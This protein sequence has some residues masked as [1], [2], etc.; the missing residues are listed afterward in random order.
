MRRFYSAVLIFLLVGYFVGLAEAQFGRK[1]AEGAGH[2]FYQLANFPGQELSQSKLFVFLSI[3]HDALVFVRT[4]SGFAAHYKLG[5]YLYGE[6]KNLLFE[7]S[8]RRTVFVKQYDDTN[9]PA[10]F[11][12]LNVSTTQT[13]G[14]YRL[15]L[16]LEDREVPKP[17]ILEKEVRIRDFRK[18]PLQLSSLLLLG[19]APDSCG[20]GV[21]PEPEAVANF[22][23]DFLVCFE[24]AK[25]VPEAAQL[26]LEVVS[27]H[28]RTVYQADT[29][30]FSANSVRKCFV[31]P[32]D[33]TPLRNGYYRIRVKAFGLKR[34]PPVETDFRVTKA[35]EFQNEQ[36]LDDAI[37]VLSY[38]ARPEE[39]EKIKKADSFVRKKRLFD[40][41]WKKLDPTPDTP[42]NELQAEFYERVA[43]ANEKFSLTRDDGWRTDRGRIYIVYGP[44]DS[45][46]HQRDRQFRDYE[47]WRY[48]NLHKEFVFWDRNGTGNYQL[49]RAQ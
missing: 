40:A 7:K 23:K 44:P 48:T 11:D 39:L 46:E 5:V 14:K 10:V 2:F 22:P 47:I 28:G 35:M 9:R 21:L 34:V 16:R 6:K 26:L 37:A 4:D 19:A 43:Y 3:P 18:S 31:T 36:E 13:A 27:R 17:R 33:V 24:A 29:L 41:F 32:V 42:F 25:Q 1:H 12:R 20:Q 49:V 15:V 30:V 38:I 45:V 8:W